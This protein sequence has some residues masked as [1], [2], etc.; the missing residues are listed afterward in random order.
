[1][2]WSIFLLLLASLIL[3]IAPLLS[4]NDAS[5][6]LYKAE[7]VKSTTEFDAPLTEMHRFL[8]LAQP[9]DTLFISVNVMKCNLKQIKFKYTLTIKHLGTGRVYTSTGEGRDV[10]LSLPTFTFRKG[11]VYAVELAVSVE[12]SR[13]CAYSIEGVIKGGGKAEVIRVLFLQSLLMLPALLGVAVYVALDAYR[14]Y[15]AS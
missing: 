15:K 11:G 3:T 13:T 6:E 1:M 5:L 7:P 12:G 4:I 2:R 8:V 10:T 14:T 9:N